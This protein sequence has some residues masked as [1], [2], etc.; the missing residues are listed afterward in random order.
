MLY[1]GGIEATQKSNSNK[2][3]PKKNTSIEILFQKALR[4][5]EIKFET[6]RAIDGICCPDI[7]IEPNIIVECDGDYWHSLPGRKARDKAH[8]SDLQ[9][10]GYKVFRFL[11]SEITKDVDSCVERIFKGGI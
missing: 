4:Q 6:H 10:A 8:N 7:F 2:Y 5:C 1:E 9:K 11:G 3:M